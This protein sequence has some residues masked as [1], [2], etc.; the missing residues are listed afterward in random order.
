[1]RVTLSN[2]ELGQILFALDHLVFSFSER[3]INE[4]ST[5]FQNCKKLIKKLG[6]K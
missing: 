5:V 1:M 3:E 6:G 2:D 4:E